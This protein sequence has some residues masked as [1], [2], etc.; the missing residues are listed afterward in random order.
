RSV[1]VSRG[2]ELELALEPG[3]APVRAEPAAPAGAARRN[4]AE[5]ERSHIVEVLEG[6]GWKVSGPGG[7]AQ[8]LGLRPTTLESRMKKLGIA[9]PR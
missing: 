8:I 7:A 1:I 6:C 5:I 2:P 9:R 3:G 4:L